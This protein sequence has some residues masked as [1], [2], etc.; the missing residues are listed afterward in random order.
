MG[1]TLGWRDIVIDYVHVD[2]VNGRLEKAAQ[3]VPADQ[4][5]VERAACA[6]AWQ[7]QTRVGC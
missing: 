4:R 7:A 5:A 3:D 1:K 6:L 2:T